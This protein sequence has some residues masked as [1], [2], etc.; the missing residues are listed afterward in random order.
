[1]PH[2]CGDRR[3]HRALGHG[4]ARLP[5]PTDGVV[6]KVNDFAVR[7]TGIHGQGPEMGR[8]LQVQGR[9]GAHAAG[10]R[11]VPGGTHGSRDAC[12][13][14]RT[15]AAGR[16]DRA[17]RHAAQR[18]TDG[19][20][21]HPPGRYGLRREGRRDHSEDHR[22]RPLAA[23]RRQPN[24]SNTS[25]RAPNAARRWCATRAKRSTT[26]PIRAD[27]GPRSS[28]ASSTSSA[29]KPSTSR[30]WARRPWNCSTKTAG[31]RRGGPL[32][33]ARRTAGSLPR[34]GEKSADNIIRSIERSKQVPFHRVLFG[35][36]HPLRGRNDGQIPRRALP[37][38][39]RCDESH[40]RGAGGGRRGGRTHRR[41]HH[42]VFRRGREPADHPP[43]ARRGAAIRGRSA[44]A[45]F[46]APGGQDIRGRE[47]SRAAAT[48]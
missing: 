28:D 32:R 7:R 24:R 8:G 43:S 45:G 30:G 27:A 14:P 21:G 44:R 35:L 20:A 12:G 34:L 31:A 22:G 13:E 26:A 37:V 3:L 47:N 5:F 42:R 39:G 17:T 23:S 1:M 48:R 9:T 18:R 15:G 10:Q 38:A 2:C 4:A 19:P 41:R 46:G 40:A 29:A 33:P 11:V 25:P 16:D 6:I 36:G